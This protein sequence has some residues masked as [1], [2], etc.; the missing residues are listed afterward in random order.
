MIVPICLVFWSGQLRRPDPSNIHVAYSHSVFCSEHI[1]CLSILSSVPLSSITRKC[2]HLPYGPLSTA[3]R[4]SLNCCNHPNKS[5]ITYFCACVN[6][7]WVNYISTYSSLPHPHS[8]QRKS[9]GRSSQAP[10]SSSSW[11]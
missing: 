1:V 11:T 2:Y 4:R 7:F 6:N 3:F 9:T 5:I 8:G 10:S